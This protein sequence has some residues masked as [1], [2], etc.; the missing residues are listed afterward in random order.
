MLTGLRGFDVLHPFRDGRIRLEAHHEQG[1]FE[2]RAEIPGIDPTSDV[3]MTAG[4]R[5]LLIRAERVRSGARRSEFRYGYLSGR[6]PL[7]EGANPVDITT[8]YANGILTVSVPLSGAAPGVGR[9]VRLPV[10]H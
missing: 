6:V 3:E 5:G 4:E 8:T 10:T 9:R 2:V 1:W 7:P